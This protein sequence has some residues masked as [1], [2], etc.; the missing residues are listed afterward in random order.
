MFGRLGAASIEVDGVAVPRRYR[1]S[2]RTKHKQE[3]ELNLED[4]NEK[5][6]VLVDDDDDN[7]QY[8]VQHSGSDLEDARDSSDGVSGSE[9]DESTS[10]SD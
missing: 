10:S 6:L 4:F 1:E 8:D 5:P 3:E 9:S 2:T 7:D